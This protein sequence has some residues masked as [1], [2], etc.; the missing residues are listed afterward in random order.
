KQ[1]DLR[2]KELSSERKSIGSNRVN[3]RRR[4]RTAQNRERRSQP[5]GQR[6]RRH[7]R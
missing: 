3:N 7:R 2:C 1:K 4:D 5:K 6:F